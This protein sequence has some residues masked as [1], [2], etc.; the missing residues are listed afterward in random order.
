VRSRQSER[1]AKTA[2]LVFLV[3]ENAEFRSRMRAAQ[4]HETRGLVLGI[5]ASSFAL[6]DAAVQNFAGTS[7]TPSLKTHVGEIQTGPDGSIEKILARVDFGFRLP[8]RTHK[9]YVELRH[10]CRHLVPE[11]TT[12]NVTD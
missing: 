11:L 12:G 3:S 8:A 1:L 6:V 5:H 4:E 9:S 10:L 2:Q 7:C